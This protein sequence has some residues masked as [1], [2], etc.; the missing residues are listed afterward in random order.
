MVP[1]PWSGTDYPRFELFR[2]VE[3]YMIKNIHTKL[4]V[5]LNKNICYE[6][7]SLVH[8]ILQKHDIFF[9]LSEGTALG[10]R[11]NNDF[12]DWDDD[13]DIAIWEKDK[14]KLCTII[15]EFKKEGFSY[16]GKGISVFGINVPLKLHRKGE[17]IDIDITGMNTFC[18]ANGKSDASELLNCLYDFDKID[19]Q[20]K[21][22]N[23]PKEK[24]LV[25]LYGDNWMTPIRN[26]KTNSIR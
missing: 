20:G 2:D 5:P 12:I 16:A 21:I 7:L 22:Y 13:V 4:H 1:L 3:N 26:Q 24:Y 18:V 6:N 11:R 8:D 15:K 23:I 10:F 14:D 17:K 19:I 9:W 25:K